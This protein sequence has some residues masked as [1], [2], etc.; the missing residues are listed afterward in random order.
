M[1][2]KKRTVK[3]QGLSGITTFITD[4]ENRYFNITDIPEELSTGRSSFKILGSSFLRENVVPIP[5]LVQ[6]FPLKMELVDFQG[7]PIYME[8]VFNYV[9]GQG[10]RVSIEVY[11]DVPEGTAELTILGE[12]DP[13]KVDFEIPQHN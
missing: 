7:R 5:F 13:A 4:T 3:L 8:P 10:I 2:V 9:E 11:D 1:A 6:R 12:I